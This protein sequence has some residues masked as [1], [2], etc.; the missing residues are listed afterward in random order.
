MRKIKF[1]VGVLLILTLTVMIGGCDMGA[2]NGAYEYTL[3]Q[4]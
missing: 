3:I 1:L 4:P 2:S